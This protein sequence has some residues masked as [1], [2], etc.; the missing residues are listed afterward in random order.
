LVTLNGVNRANVSVQ[1]A[2]NVP[3]GQSAGLVARYHGAG[4]TNMYVASIASRG[5]GY[6]A[7]IYVNFN[8]VWTLLASKS[9]GTVGQGTLR[10]TTI[11]T[12]MQ[13]FWN[14][15]LIVSATDSRLTSGSVGLR[16]SQG[17]MMADFSAS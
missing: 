17:A 11:G 13:L 3:A 9:I 5:S 15:A 16:V 4:D 12:S 2:I 1:A 10:F 8:G 14:G 6:V 7:Q